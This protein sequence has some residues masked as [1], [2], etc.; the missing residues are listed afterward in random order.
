LTSIGTPST[1]ES[2]VLRGAS[3]Q[4]VMPSACTEHGT[5][6]TLWLNTLTGGAA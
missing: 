3:V 1:G 2:T 6:G 5:G 4:K